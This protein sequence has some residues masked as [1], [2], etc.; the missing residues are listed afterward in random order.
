MTPPANKK[1][2]FCLV[3]S[4]DS[5]SI[6]HI[7]PESL[8]NIDYVLPKGLVCDR[9][10]QYF[11]IKIEKLLLDQDYF[12]YIRHTRDITSKKGNTVPCQGFIMHPLGGKINLY[13]HD[14]GLSIGID[15]PEIARLIQ[16]GVINSL[17][18]PHYTEPLPSNLIL[19]RLLA[20]IAYE[21]FI[22][23]IHFNENLLNEAFANQPFDDLRKYARFGPQKIKFWNYHQRPL[24]PPEQIF[25]DGRAMSEN[26]EILHEF[27][28]H[29]TKENQLLFVIALFGIEYVINMQNPTETLYEV[30]LEERK[31][32]SPLFDPHEIPIPG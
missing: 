14:D 13:K 15:D 5:K 3:P 2:I 25:H 17:Y 31:G 18:I 12:K 24:Y 20:K 23:K 9:C 1:C 16:T 32:K 21:A 28:F 10:N 4:D 29:F 7:I 8:G 30:I 27:T 11:A 6:E 26:F 19:S 22:L